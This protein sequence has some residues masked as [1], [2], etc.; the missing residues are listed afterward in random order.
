MSRKKLAYTRKFSSLISPFQRVH[1][2][3]LQ[4]VFVP[5]AG[6]YPGLLGIGPRPNWEKNCRQNVEIGKKY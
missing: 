1:R 3:F 2:N 4:G 6:L 5:L